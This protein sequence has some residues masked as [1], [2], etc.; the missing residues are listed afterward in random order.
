MT[1]K[2]AHLSNSQRQAVDEITVS[3]DQ[4][5]GLQGTAGAGKTTSL[6]AIREAAEREGYQVKGLAPTSRAAQQL[7]EAGIEAMTLQRHLAQGEYAD[8]GRKRLYFVDESSLASTKQMHDFFK[9]LKENDRVLLV[10]DTR[11][12][13][14]VEAGRPFEQL[15]DAGMRTARLD[16]IVRQKDAALKEVVEQLA[17]GEVR[18]A[19]CNLETQGRVREILDPQ[20]RLQE[21]ARAYAANPESTLVISPDNK[22]RAAIN[23]LIHR[24]LQTSGQLGEDHRLRV[25]VSRQEMTGADRQWAAQYE[26]DDVL[27]YSKGSKAMGIRASEYMR[28]ETMD[29]E[30]NLVT[31]KRENGDLLTYDPR[32]LQGVTVHKESQR[33][34]GHTAAD[35]M[36]RE[37]SS[38]VANPC[39]DAPAKGCDWN[40]KILGYRVPRGR[41]KHAHS[42]LSLA[43]RIWAK[44]SSISSLKCAAIRARCTPKVPRI[45]P[46]AL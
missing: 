27:R 18:Q 43:G 19:V 38:V 15:Q 42:S 17:R 23:Q 3:R 31:V 6:A 22:S 33:E 28:V 13:Q 25:L 35:L 37:L 10:G 45:S 14:G 29:H 16:E 1:E 24:E 40:C 5:T 11:Q 9:R 39:G 34:F 12:H 32:R 26:P 41:S 7:G 30:R 36:N 44:S 8:D 4:I 20:E 21:I 46:S 2:L